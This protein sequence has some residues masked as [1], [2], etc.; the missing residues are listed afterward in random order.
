MDIRTDAPGSGRR[1]TLVAALEALFAR[2]PESAHIVEVGTSRNAS[3]AAE[4]ADGW[5]T[6]MFGWYAAQ[7]NGRV[8]SID[9]RP[10]AL[11][12]ARKVVGPWGGPVTF[13]QGRAEDVVAGRAPID[14]LY[15]DG[16]SDAQ[17]H[18][19]IYR[20]L[21]EPAALVLWDDIVLESDPPG[22]WPKW[23]PKGTWEWP[24]WAIKG[25]LAIP[26]MLEDGYRIRFARD[27]QVL[28]EAP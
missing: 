21:P 5:G 28:L 24:K 15:M 10:Q 11:A 17:V 12:N 8:T 2:T 1:D 3:P 22:R 20:A 27:R 16:P 23:P 13:V 18:L 14:L 4:L 26:E 19:D 6:R 7:T 25:T 9:T